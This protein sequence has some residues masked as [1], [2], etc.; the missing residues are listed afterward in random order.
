MVEYCYSVAEHDAE[1]PWI[2]LGTSPGAVTIEEGMGF[3][4]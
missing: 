2:V 1:R 4:K 3:L